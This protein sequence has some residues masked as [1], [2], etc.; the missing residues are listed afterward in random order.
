MYMNI[1]DVHIHLVTYSLSYIT[2]SLDTL[3]A[4]GMCL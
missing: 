3:L 1:R 2:V 4:V